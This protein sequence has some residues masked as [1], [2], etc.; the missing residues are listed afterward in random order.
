MAEPSQFVYDPRSRR[1]RNISSGRFISSNQVRSAVDIIIDKEAQN[2]RG[3]AQQL[4][5]GNINLAE[6]QLQM[7]A[8]VKRLH[9][10]MAL[11]ANGGINNTSPGDLG[12]IANLIKEQ[13]KFLRGMA[14]D[15]KS[16]KQPLDGTLLARV[17]LYAESARGT[18]EAVR[19]RAARIGGQTQQKSILGIADHC[20]ECVS[21]AKKGW[22]P[23][24]SLI[25]IGER[26]C[27]AS[28]HCSMDYR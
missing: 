10:A 5:D 17:A 20:S 19:E 1:Y 12:F 9:V 13:H 18:H 8:N 11:A 24:G 23:I 2:F 22:S 6:F 26:I 21:E 27:K 28:C 15:I 3:V 25:P 7:A 14:K 4:L 16:G